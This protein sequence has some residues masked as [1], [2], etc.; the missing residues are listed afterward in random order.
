MKWRIREPKE[1]Q[2]PWILI[3]QIS[4]KT[5]ESCA[6]IKFN[7]TWS[8]IATKEGRKWLLS[9]ENLL[10]SQLSQYQGVNYGMPNKSSTIG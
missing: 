1:Q 8:T 7:S 6:K 4:Q 9:L 10:G 2:I 3:E 5:T